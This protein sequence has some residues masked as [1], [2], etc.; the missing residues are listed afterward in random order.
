MAIASFKLDNLD[1]AFPKVKKDM[2]NYLA[3]GGNDN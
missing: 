3:D 2:D 1:K